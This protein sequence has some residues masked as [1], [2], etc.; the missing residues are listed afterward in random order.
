MRAWSA[1]TTRLAAVGKAPLARPRFDAATVAALAA[2]AVPG[3]ADHG[4]ASDVDV[5]PAVLRLAAESIVGVLVCLEVGQGCGHW[6]LLRRSG[7][8][9]LQ[10]SRPR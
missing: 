1:Q 7:Q 2:F 3:G 4:D 9:A 8:I 10:P 6:N 5:A